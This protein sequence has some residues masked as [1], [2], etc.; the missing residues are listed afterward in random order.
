[1]FLDKT[2]CDSVAF[3]Y[4][5]NCGW[6]NITQE[7]LKK[8]LYA[9]AYVYYKMSYLKDIS[10]ELAQ[11]IY[12]S[13]ANGIYIEDKVDDRQWAFNIIWNFN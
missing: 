4:I 7:Q 5:K 1:M 13:A 8:E 2:T 12:N 10:I 9:H 6:K 11:S 3:T